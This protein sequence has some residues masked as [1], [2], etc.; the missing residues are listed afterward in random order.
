MDILAFSRIGLGGRRQ[1]A[2]GGGLFKNVEPVR[3][4]GLTILGQDPYNSVQPLPRA[5][6]VDEDG[7]KIKRAEPVESLEDG[8]QE[9]PIRLSPPPRIFIE[10]DKPGI[11]TASGAQ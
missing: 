10:D 5:V 6:L 8:P 9:L 2:G 7:G 11:T 3:L 4:Q 1:E